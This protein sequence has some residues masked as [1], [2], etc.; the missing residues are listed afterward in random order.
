LLSALRST[1]LSLLLLSFVSVSAQTSGNRNS[2]YSAT[3][4]VTFVQKLADGTT[5]TRESTATEARDSQGRTVQT[6]T[7]T[8]IGGRST[9]H[10]TVMDPVAK[11]MT[12]WSSLGKQATTMHLSEPRRISPL[13]ATTTI[14]S[15]PTMV[16]A[17]GAGDFPVAIG[18]SEAVGSTS[19]PHVKPARQIDRLG[20]KTIAGVYAEGV[21]TTTTYPVGYMGNDRPIAVVREILTAPD[22]KITLL[23]TDN[24]PRTGL[25]STEVIDIVRAEPDPA[26]FLPPEGY[27]IRDHS[28]GSN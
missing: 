8:G 10:T 27:T 23:A 1:A 12:T 15:G 16:S 17:A 7:M 21:R 5:I 11:T 6:T 13:S 2:P 4:K 9:T 22:L 3:K 26:L 25:Q 20:G 28:P 18:P 24:D 19:D 14:S